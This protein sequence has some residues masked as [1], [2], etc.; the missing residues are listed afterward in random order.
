MKKIFELTLQMTALKRALGPTADRILKKAGI[1]HKRSDGFAN[2][3]WQEIRREEL[4]F[5][6]GLWQEKEKEC[7]GNFVELRP[8]PVWTTLADDEAPAVFCGLH[9]T[10]GRSLNVDYSQHKLL[11]EAG[12]R[13]EDVEGL[14]KSG[15]QTVRAAMETRNCIFLGSPKYNRCTDHAL[16]AFWPL[17]QNR[18]FVF[19]WPDL[20]EKLELE[21]D[22]VIDSHF[23]EVGPHEVRIGKHKY[24]LKTRSKREAAIQDT[25]WDIGIAVVCRQPFKTQKKVT[26]IL[27]CGHQNIAT[28][29]MLEDLLSG[30]YFGENSLTPG[31]PAVHLLITPW[32]RLG[33]EEWV[34]WGAGHRWVSALNS[35]DIRRV[36]KGLLTPP[37]RSAT[38]RPKRP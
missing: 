12:F 35:T 24:R 14:S 32:R 20:R 27:L 37:G 16:E 21:A 23:C 22:D 13:L 7:K 2:D 28:E 3:S 31:V 11:R 38:S 34:R 8:H 26:S 5:L 4:K 1:S 9:P 29:R 19:S 33:E 15:M 25:G 6:L 10:S 18:P 17:E 36:S 30:V